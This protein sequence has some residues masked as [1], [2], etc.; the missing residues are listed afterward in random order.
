MGS[1]TSL[2]FYILKP[3]QP[4]LGFKAT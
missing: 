1:S 2:Q 4:G 3:I